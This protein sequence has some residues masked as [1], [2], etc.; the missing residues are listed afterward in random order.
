M[1]TKRNTLLK[2]LLLILMST[3]LAA[4]HSPLIPGS[5][6]SF[7]NKDVEY[8][9]RESTQMTEAELNRISTIRPITLALI[10]E[11]REPVV[12]ARHNPSLE[13]QKRNYVYR[14]GSGDVLSIKIW[15][16]PEFNSFATTLN[17]T[18]QQVNQGTWV[19]ESGNI[20]YPMAGK[21]HVRGK[22]LPEVQQLLTQ[23]LSRYFKNPQLDVNISEFRSQN[24]SVTGAVKQSGRLP[25]NNIPMTLL[26]A[27]SLA[28]GFTGSA[29]TTNIRLTRNGIDHSI[30]LQDLLQRGD[31]IQN[32][33]LKHGDIVHIP[34]RTDVQVYVL[35]EVG[36]QN[37]LTLDNNGLNLTEALA[38]AEGMNQN[39]ANA[40][41][42]FVIR[43]KPIQAD[44]KSIDVYQL[45]LKDATAYALGTQFALK[46]DDVVY[47]TAAP[48]ARWNRTLSQI[49]PSVNSAIM[50][51]NTFK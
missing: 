22:T 16:Q 13:A 28:G 33:L 14:L 34:E 50:L 45:N 8:S 27:V 43:S 31:M 26:D 47:V 37:V 41:G 12:H 10:H 36:K 19:D 32:R 17:S 1:M 49:M 44:G 24:I 46:P 23:R 39:L 15:N 21:I 4:C 9:N 42:V 25:I 30:S 6:I 3:T 5:N 20:F 2:P 38:K 35:G 48:V 51:N 11:M 40:T 7:K 29:D 18:N